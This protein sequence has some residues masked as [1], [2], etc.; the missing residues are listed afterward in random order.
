[1][2]DEKS[3]LAK[4]AKTLRERQG[5]TIAETARRAEMSTSMLWK[6]E[7]GQTTLTYGKLMN[8]AAAL[9]VP[10][11]DLF[12]VGE[13][14]FR[15]GGRRVVERRGTA[16][17]VDFANNFFHFLATDIESK[18]FFPSLVE[19]GA[20]GGNPEAHGGEEFAYVMKGRVKFLCEGYAPVSLKE[21][22]SVYFDASLPHRYL[23]DDDKVP[24]QMLCVY[25]RPEVEPVSLENPIS[26]SEDPGDIIPISRPKRRKVAG[27]R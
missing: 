6:V 14:T 18:A 26:E 10:V 12:S 19:V 13:A 5:W 4:Q 20:D 21:G 2:A 7:N 27:G 24:A 23:C 8:L 25:S 11:G 15:K 22:D 9:E 16:P 17:I 3:T 1:M